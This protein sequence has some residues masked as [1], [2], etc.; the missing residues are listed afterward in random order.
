MLLR[1]RPVNNPYVYNGT[2]NWYNEVLREAFQMNHNISVSGGSEKGTYYLS[3]G[4]IQEDGIIQTNN[5]K[6]FTFRA[7][8]DV[9]ITES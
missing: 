5:F 4:Y 8:N 7:N 2:T 9:N 3:A 6:R 1:V